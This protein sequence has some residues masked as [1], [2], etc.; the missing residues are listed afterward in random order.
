MVRTRCKRARFGRRSRW[1]SSN[2]LDNLIALLSEHNVRYCVIGGQGSANALAATYYPSSIRAS[3]VGWVFG[4]G[5]IGSIVGPLV[6]GIL[7]V[8]HWGTPSL[9]LVAAVPALCAAIAAIAL[10]RIA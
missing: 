1:T 2:F 8:Q 3:G 6:G 9:F 5:R 4:I 10:A 7:I